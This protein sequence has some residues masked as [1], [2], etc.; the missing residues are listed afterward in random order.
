M[1]KTTK[2]D[3]PLILSDYEQFVIQQERRRQQVR[4]WYAKWEETRPQGQFG[5]WNI[6]DRD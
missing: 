3:L 6:S 1:N 4:D 5:T 2:P